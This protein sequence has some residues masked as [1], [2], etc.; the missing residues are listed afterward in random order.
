MPAL[1]DETLLPCIPAHP[2]LSN[3]TFSDSS[4]EHLPLPHPP[5]LL[6]PVKRTIPSMAVSCIW[7]CVKI[8]DVSIFPSTLEAA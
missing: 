1:L 2:I 6:T 3:L 4:A 8:S 7:L 5:L